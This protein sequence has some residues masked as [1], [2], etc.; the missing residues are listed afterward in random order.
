MDKQFEAAAKRYAESHLTGGYKWPD[1]AEFAV[2]YCMPVRE[3]VKDAKVEFFLNIHDLRDW[4]DEEGLKTEA[5]QA[6]E[7]DLGPNAMAGMHK[8][9]GDLPLTA[10]ER[11]A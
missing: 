6:Y 8:N 5:Y 3:G 2:K 11:N 10:A 9:P 4:I 1:A 7:W